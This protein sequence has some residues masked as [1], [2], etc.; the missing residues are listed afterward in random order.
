MTTYNYDIAKRVLSETDKD[1]F[2]CCYLNI[3]D[4]NAVN[5]EKAANDYG[6]ASVQSFKKMIQNAFK[7]VKDGEAAGG[8]EGTGDSEVKEGKKK[9]ATPGSR[10][11][12]AKA[13]GAEQDVEESPTKKQKVAAGVRKKKGEKAAAGSSTAAGEQDEGNDG[14]TKAP[15][16]GVKEEMC[17]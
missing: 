1:R 11:K 15:V 4:P 13:E 17:D 12:K 9:N 2:L 5:W 14:D 16:R 8:D 3:S 10:K 6:S 7:K